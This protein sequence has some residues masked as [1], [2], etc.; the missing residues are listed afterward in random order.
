VIFAR[1]GE[2]A[3]LATFPFWIKLR[4]YEADTNSNSDQVVAEIRDG[5]SDDGIRPAA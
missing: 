3:G 1:H 4:R 2:N 5:V